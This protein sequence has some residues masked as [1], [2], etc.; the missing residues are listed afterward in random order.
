M[1]LELRE[2]SEE[3]LFF[4]IGL[5][6]EAEAKPWL[7]RWTRERHLEAF[8][9]DDE[10]PLIVIEDGEPVGYALLSGIGNENAGIEVRRI[11]VARKGE[12]VGRR[13]LALVVDRAFE[14]HGAHRVWLDLMT[15]NAR[16]ERAYEAVGFVKEGVMRDS[17]RT[18]DGWESM[19]V[20]SMLRREWRMRRLYDL[21]NEREVERLL[22]RMSPEVDWPNAIEG[23]RLFGREAVRAYW[24]AQFEQA[25]PRLEVTAVDELEDG[26]IQ[27]R[28]RQY[29][30][31]LDGDLIGQGE[32][33]H[34]Y[35]FEGELI[36]RME[37]VAVADER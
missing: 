18:D 23:G 6:T 19:I 30:Y 21:F 8:R 26:R 24:L 32:V 14:R 9:R 37:I 15:G 35:E 34:V 27:V 28:L 11:V 16:A 12:G 31:D 33:L 10:E 1:T 17:L 29:V 20:M 36:A 3:D 4:M 5:E 2:A 22:E 13:A 7:A 25:D